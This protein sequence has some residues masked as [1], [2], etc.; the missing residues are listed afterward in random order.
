MGNST[1]LHD[2][3]VQTFNWYA[4]NWKLWL[5]IAEKKEEIVYSSRGDNFG[6][7]PWT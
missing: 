6:L 3:F 2:I 5:F 4:Q 1:M 7:C